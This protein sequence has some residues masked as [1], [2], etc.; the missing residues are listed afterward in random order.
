LVNRRQLV[1]KVSVATFGL[2]LIATTFLPWLQSGRR[3]RS[4]YELVGV[5]RRLQQVPTTLLRDATFWWP[6]VPMLVAIGVMLVL[7]DR[8]TLGAVLGLLGSAYVGGFAIAF[9]RLDIP[10]IAGVQVGGTVL[11]GLLASCAFALSVLVN[12]RIARRA[13]VPATIQPPVTTADHAAGRPA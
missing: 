3:R 6:V 4:S 10:S 12:V 8:A 5:A 9:W 13:V 2:V 7:W 11:C 1:A